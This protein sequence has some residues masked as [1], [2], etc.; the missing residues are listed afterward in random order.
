MLCKLCWKKP[1][2]Q[3]SIIK[4]QITIVKNNATPFIISGDMVCTSSNSTPAMVRML[5]TCLHF[6][7]ARPVP[8]QKRRRQN[9]KS[10][11]CSIQADDDFQSSQPCANLCIWSLFQL[12]LKEIEYSH[13]NCATKHRKLPLNGAWYD[14]KIGCIQYL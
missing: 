7:R 9:Y 14:S 2:P 3:D 12:P 6:S 5:A 8:D 11:L 1:V 13:F 4:F 10:V